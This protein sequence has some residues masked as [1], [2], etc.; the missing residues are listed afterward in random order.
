MSAKYKD[1]V[2]DVWF[3]VVEPEVESVLSGNICA[4][5]GLLK[6]V[7]QLT[8]NTPLGRTRVELD[9]YPELFKGLGCLPGTY[10][11]ELADGATPVVHSPRKIPVP[12]REKVVEELKR[13]E[14]LGVIERQEEPT[15]WVNSLVVVQKPNGSVR[16]CID[17]RDL[18]AAMKRSHYPMKTVDEVASRLQGANTFSI[19]AAKSGF[20][21]LKLDEESSLLC[22]FNT[23]LTDIETRYAPIETEMLAVVFACRKFHQY[24]YARS[25]TVETDHK[26]LQAI[27]TK[28]LSQVPLRLQKMILNLRG[29]DVEIRYIPES[30]QVLADTLSRASVHSDDSG[31]DEEFKEINLVLS[32]SDERYEE[33]QNE[34]KTDPE[35]QAVLAMVENGWPDTNVQVSVEAKLY[36]AFRDEAPVPLSPVMHQ[37]IPAVPSPPGAN[38]W[39]L[40]FF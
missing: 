10:R 12:Q 37:S 34:T 17:P 14:K 36:W 28:P 20:W 3:F 18:N 13:M 19:L 25:V 7:H 2:E 26:P 9:D 29:Y 8:S 16:L 35:L 11:I 31:T 21:Q 30:K 24:I 27:S 38:P 39:A 32:V 1:N 6:R 33:L 15:E 40:A 5:L 4:K 23:P 22:T